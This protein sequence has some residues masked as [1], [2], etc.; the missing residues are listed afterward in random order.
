MAWRPELSRAIFLACR[1][2]VPTHQMFQWFSIKQTLDSR[3]SSCQIPTITTMSVLS[4]PKT[5]RS[6]KNELVHE[7]RVFPKKVVSEAVVRASLAAPGAACTK[8]IPES[9]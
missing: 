8:V 6:V 4:T 5:Q 2:T 7:N 9:H 1:R 3:D